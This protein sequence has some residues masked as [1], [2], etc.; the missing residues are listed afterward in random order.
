V[1]TYDVEPGARP[2][3]AAPTEFEQAEPTPFLRPGPSEPARSLPFTLSGE[4]AEI[5][6]PPFI[7]Q[8][9][10]FTARIEPGVTSLQYRIWRVK[11]GRQLLAALGTAASTSE[12]AL[13]G[14]A[15][16]PASLPPGEYVLELVLP[17][18]THW[19]LTVEEV[20]SDMSEPSR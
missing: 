7:T 1:L 15:L 10:E 11:R 18:A 2:A 14:L 8:T 17:E 5:Q 12:R 13:P 20:P 3:L 4:G 19:S 6:T 9:G 16:P